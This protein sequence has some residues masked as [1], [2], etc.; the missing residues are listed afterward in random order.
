MRGKYHYSHF[1]VET[2]SSSRQLIHPR[3]QRKSLWKLKKDNTDGL[4]SFPRAMSNG[5]LASGSGNYCK[6]PFRRQEDL[7]MLQL[8]KNN[9]IH[10]A[11]SFTI[12]YKWLFRLQM[13]LRMCL[14][15]E[16]FFCT[17]G[18]LCIRIVHL[19]ARAYLHARLGWIRGA[20]IQ[21]SLWCGRVSIV[22]LTQK[23]SAC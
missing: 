18:H 9:F 15:T 6:K 5:L 10:A 14:W 22:I 20:Q 8:L 4:V 11:T 1:E 2:N 7:N 16:V 21:L 3:R 12:K 13:C 19:R 23:S 17:Y